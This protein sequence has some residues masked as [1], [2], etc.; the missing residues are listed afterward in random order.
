MTI[1]GT[2][3]ST[4]RANDGRIVHHGARQMLATVWRVPSSAVE[5][6]FGCFISAST[7]A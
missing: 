2:E 6:G 5:Q 1:G 3:K 4:D 7:A